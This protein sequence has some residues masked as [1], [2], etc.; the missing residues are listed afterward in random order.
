MIVILS[1]DSDSNQKEV[2]SVDQ[3]LFSKTSIG[4]VTYRAFGVPTVDFH[5][6]L[7]TKLYLNWVEN[8]CDNGKPTLSGFDKK[9]LV[10]KSNDCDIELKEYTPRYKG[11]WGSSEIR[12]LPYIVRNEIDH[13]EVLE[14]DKNLWSEN[15]LKSSIE[16]LVDI[17]KKEFCSSKNTEKVSM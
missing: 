4:E 12:T 17:Y 2:S 6:L 13:P 10:E 16:L 7:F 14:E 3:L 15:N 8:Y 11:N 9:Y 1:I 5:Q